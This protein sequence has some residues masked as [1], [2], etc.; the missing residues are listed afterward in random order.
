MTRREFIR[1]ASAGAAASAAASASA[2]EAA[3]KRTPL[4]ENQYAPAPDLGS[5][6][7]LFGKLSA[8]CRPAMSFLEAAYDDPQAWAD[9]AR[10]RLL[11]L[12]HYAP[13]PCDPAPELVESV[14]RGTY[15]R[16]RVLINTTP[17]IRIPVYVLVPKGLDGPAP[18][19]VALHDHG[20][21]YLW[22]K[23]KVVEVAPENA[24][25]AAFKQQYYGGRSTADE[26][27]KRGF[28][29][30]AADMLH[31]GERAMYLD[32]DPERIRNRTRDVDEQDVRAFNA[33]SWAHED[34]LGRTA[35][36]C[37]ATWSGMIAWD[38][39]RVADYLAGRPEV[40]SARMGCV[41]LSVGSVRTIF[42]GAL[43]PLIRA[44]VAVCWMAEYQAMARNHVRYG[45]GF[46]K[47]IPGLYNDLDWPDL[48][49]LHYPGRLMT[50]NGLQDQLYPLEAARAAVDKV[51]AIFAKAG[52]SDHYEGVFF[53]GPHEFNP[54]MQDTAFD[55]L[56]E[57][58]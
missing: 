45:I 7:S 31:W 52:V 30:I 43:H 27:A 37:G 9:V 1:N 23:E 55:W 47:L 44:S 3:V 41:G 8:D 53:E 24:R 35:F 38:D 21:F 12:L 16:E 54:S 28:V 19:V 6:W 20:G 10:A 14:D 42:L 51:H 33:R 18:A 50:I 34:V 46:T 57:S 5:H 40:D 26:L 32:A 29:V 39:L 36:T 2:Q 56:Q 58:L 17:H 13:P 4:P 25:L 15:V 11:D 48:A 49:G 22:G